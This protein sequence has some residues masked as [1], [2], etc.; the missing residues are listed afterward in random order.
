[1]AEP[2]RLEVLRTDAVA[3][4]GSAA[5]AEWRCGNCRALLAKVGGTPAYGARTEIKCW[6]CKAYNVWGVT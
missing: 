1:M 4:L 3:P 2:V 6:R 5:L